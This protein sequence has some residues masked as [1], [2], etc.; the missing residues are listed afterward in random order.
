MISSVFQ[1][2]K[3]PGA[4]SG[5]GFCP[6][7][8]TAPHRLFFFSYELPIYIYMYHV[9]ICAC[10]FQWHRERYEKKRMRERER[11]ATDLKEEEK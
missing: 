1:V 11:A 6:P 7:M 10:V 9:C 5:G 8:K 2:P 4:A 3:P